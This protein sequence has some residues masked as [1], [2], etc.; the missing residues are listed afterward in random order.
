MYDSKI[1]N[2][3]PPIHGWRWTR[4]ISRQGGG[5]NVWSPQAWPAFAISD[6]AKTSS[7]SPPKPG[8]FLTTSGSGGRPLK[9]KPMAGKSWWISCWTLK[10]TTGVPTKKSRIG[11]IGIGSMMRSKVNPVANW[12]HLGKGEFMFDYSMSCFINS[13][14]KTYVAPSPPVLL[15]F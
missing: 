10:N 2:A 3:P 13:K 8:A 11:G 14:G 5:A 7:P 6:I 9:K 4:A 12:N 1:A 15:I